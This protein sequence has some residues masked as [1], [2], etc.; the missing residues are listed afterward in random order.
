MSS[1]TKNKKPYC[2]HCGSRTEN[3]YSPETVAELLDCSVQKVR[4]M[5]QRGEIGYRRIGRLVRIPSSEIER[6]GEFHPRVS[7]YFQKQLAG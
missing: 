5:I 6:I 7:D 2:P 1:S 4:K 3:L